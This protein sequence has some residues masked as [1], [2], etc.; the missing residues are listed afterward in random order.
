M[1]YSGKDL[2]RDAE[3]A[4]DFDTDSLIPKFMTVRMAKEIVEACS[5]IVGQSYYL[6]IPSL[7]LISGEDKIVDSQSTL[8][9]AHG[10]DK[11]MT[12]IIQYP[13]HYHEL[14]NELDRNEIFKEM[15]LWIDKQLK[16]PS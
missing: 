1:I 6:K 11:K 8:L 13:D 7:F 5:K 16:E 14:W 15:K 3:R 12:H 10:V 9:F 2:T 4:N